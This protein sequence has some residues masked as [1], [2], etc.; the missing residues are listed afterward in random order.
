MQKGAEQW[1][2]NGKVVGWQSWLQ[3]TVNLGG[4]GGWSSWAALRDWSWTGRQ[5]SSP[6]KT[7]RRMI[8]MELSLT[9]AAV[10]LPGKPAMIIP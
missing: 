4:G 5:E 10:R 6:Q 7:V 3:L 2:S 9:K 8:I 1:L